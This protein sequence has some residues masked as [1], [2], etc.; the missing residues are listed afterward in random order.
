MMITLIATKKLANT[1]ET[2]SWVKKIIEKTNLQ[3]S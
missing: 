2:E 3:P 1:Y